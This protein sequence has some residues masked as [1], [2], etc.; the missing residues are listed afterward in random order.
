MLAH[1]H[2]GRDQGGVS[3]DEGSAVAGEV[4]LFGQGVQDNET[5]RVAVA[6]LRIEQG[7]DPLAH[8]WFGPGQGSVALVGDDD[9]AVGA[10]P[11]DGSAQLV[12]A[13]DVAVRVAGRVQ[14]DQGGLGPGIGVCRIDGDGSGSGQASANVVGRVGD[15]GDQDL[16]ARSH[17]EQEGDPR[18]SFLGADRGDHATWA[19]VHHAAARA[20]GQDCLT[21]LGCADNRRVAVRV[22]GLGKGF[23]DEVGGVID[24]GSDAQITDSP[25]MRCCTR[26]GGRKLIP[27]E[28][29]QVKRAGQAFSHTSTLSTVTCFRLSIPHSEAAALRS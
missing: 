8:V 21:H 11:R 13:H 18:D 5:A 4:G 17:A 27:G 16:L 3:V 24:G 10:R 29:W 26:F 22:G 12:L 25:G 15:L 2:D 6:H 20:P 28:F 7:G 19:D 23:T 14:V 9:G 1:G